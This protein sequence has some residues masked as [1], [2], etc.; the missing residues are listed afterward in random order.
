MKRISALLLA[1]LLVMT[2]SLAMAG[3]TEA[4]GK[5]VVGNPTQMQGYFFTELWGH[6]TS[7]IDVRM[8]LEGYNLVNWDG[9]AGLFMF[10]Q[11]VVKRFDVDKEHK[12]LPKLFLSRLRY[13]RMEKQRHRRLENP[14]HI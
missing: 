11:N 4:S 6:S 2:Q 9:N 13:I 3:A 12:N 8:L 14:I 1:I 10:D 7:D 5:L